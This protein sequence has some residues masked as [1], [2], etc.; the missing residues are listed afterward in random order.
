M[1]DSALS[2]GQVATRAGVNASAIRFYE[3]EGLLPDAERAGG[4][5]RFGEGAVRRLQIIAVAKQAGFSLDEIRALLSST[6]SGAPVAEALKA[7]AARKLP[8]VEALIKRAEGMRGWLA[9]ASE[10]DCATVEDCA[11]FAR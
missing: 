1:E 8:E 11:L 10:C 6:D 2:I 4:R 7:L 3:R 9:A 5:R